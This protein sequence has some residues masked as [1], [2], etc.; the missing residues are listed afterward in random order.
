MNSL[1]VYI[2]KILN[3]YFDWRGWSERNSQMFKKYWHD[4]EILL[5]FTTQPCHTY[6]HTYTYMQYICMH[7]YTYVHIHV[8][9][10]CVCVYIYMRGMLMHIYN[11]TN[12]HLCI[13]LSIYPAIYVILGKKLKI[14]PSIFKLLDKWE[15][16][17]GALTS[18]IRGIQ[19]DIH[20]ATHTKKL[21]KQKTRHVK[22]YIPLAYIS[23]FCSQGV[24]SF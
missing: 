16:V 8:C 5:Y 21:W 13:Y 15:G 7:P 19:C 3:K 22:N 12:I 14:W 4:H 2:I 9:C 10:E 18:W 1:F 6:M 23:T 17:F 24:K 11:C 20:K